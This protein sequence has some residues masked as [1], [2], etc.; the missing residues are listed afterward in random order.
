MLREKRSEY[1]RCGIEGFDGEIAIECER[2]SE[3]MY[4]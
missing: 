2:V 4:V 1:G 3:E